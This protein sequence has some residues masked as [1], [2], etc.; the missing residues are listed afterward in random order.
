MSAKV[1]ASEAIGN[2]AS[3]AEGQVQ[4]FKAGG[5]KCLLALLGVGKAQEFAARALAKMAR[6]VRA[7]CALP[8]ADHACS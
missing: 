3:S 4:V 5:V 7:A 2:L 6:D 8:G 1:A